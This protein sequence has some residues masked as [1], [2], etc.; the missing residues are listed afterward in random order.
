MKKLL[1]FVVGM[2]VAVAANAALYVVG[3]NVA[4]DHSSPLQSKYDAPNALEIE[5]KDGYYCFRANGEFQIGTYR[6][7]WDEG[8]KPNTLQASAWTDKA[9]ANGVKTA[10]LS[11]PGYEVKNYPPEGWA[12]EKGN[13][14]RVT[15]DLSVIE[16]SKTS[17]FSGN[18]GGGGDDDETEYTIYFY[19]NSTNPT[20]GYVYAHIWDDNSTSVKPWADASTKMTKMDPARWVKIGDTFC[21]VYKYTFKWDK[22]PKHIILHNGSNNDNIK[23][24]PDNGV[25][26]PFVN[27]GLYYRSGNTVYTASTDFKLLNEPNDRKNYTYHLHNLTTLEGTRVQLL[28]SDDDENI[29]E[30]S[31]QYNAPLAAAQTYTVHRFDTD[32]ESFDAFGSEV[33]FNFDCSESTVNLTPGAS[34]LVIPAGL[35]GRVNFKLEL[36]GQV[37]V[38]LTVSGGEIAENPYTYSLLHSFNNATGN[39]DGKIDFTPHA[40]HF[41]ADYVFTGDEKGMV[42]KVERFQ[43]GVSVTEKQFGPSA[44]S[45]LYDPSH[46]NTTYTLTSDDDFATV[47][48][49]GLHGKVRFTLRVAEDGHPVTVNVRGG[50]MDEEYY[51]D[52]L[53]TFFFYAK[54]SDVQG[55]D[56][57]AEVYRTEGSL[58]TA[59]LT[60]EQK[61]MRRTG[62]YIQVGDEYYPVYVRSFTGDYDAVPSKVK[63]YTSDPDSPVIDMLP[64]LNYGYYTPGANA[65]TLHE[66]QVKKPS[67]KPLTLYFHVKYDRS[68][69]GKDGVNTIPMCHVYNSDDPNKQKTVFGSEDEK[70]QRIERVTERYSIW[71]YELDESD[72]E[73]FNAV[74]FHFDG[75]EKAGGYLRYDSKTLYASGKTTKYGD[76]SCYDQ[77]NWTK[78]IYSTAGLTGNDGADKNCALQSYLTYDK[79]LELDQMDIENGGRRHLYFVGWGKD[80]GH[81]F[82]YFDNSGNENTMPGDVKNALKVDEDGGCFY[83]PILPDGGSFK[84]SWLSVADAIADLPA[85]YDYDHSQREWATFDLGLIGVDR[86]YAYP[87][88]AYKPAYDR[89]AGVNGKVKM[90]RNRSIRYMNYNQADWVLPDNTD[91]LPGVGRKRWIII[92]THAEEDGEYCKTATITSFDPN[93]SVAVQVSE[94]RKR[95]EVLEPE[96]AAAMHVDCLHAA[97]ANGHVVMDKVNYAVANA[98]VSATDIAH[99]QNADF[100][101]TYSIEVNGKPVGETAADVTDFQI[102]YFPLNLDHSVQNSMT[103]RAKYTDANT[104]LSFHS[105]VGGGNVD[106]DF[107]F[108]AP[109]SISLTGRFVNEGKDEETG[110]FVFGVYVEGLDC[111][112]E[113]GNYYAYADFEFDKGTSAEFMSKGCKIDKLGYKLPVWGEWQNGHDWS[114]KLKADRELAPIFIHD[115]ARVQ[116]KVEEL[117]EEMQITCQ[118][119][120]VYPFMYNPT[121]TFV[122]NANNAPARAADAAEDFEGFKVFNSYVKNE[123]EG[124]ATFSVYRDDNVISG[125]EELLEAEAEADGEV[126]YYTIS[127]VRVY[128]EPAPGL[129]IRRQGADVKKVLV[130]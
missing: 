115:V 64:F 27:N 50:T 39:L 119:Y 75:N 66:Q 32:A 128:G 118:I 60:P 1:L 98:T 121:A 80:G 59:D 46:P 120:A 15:E 14:F 49:E 19:E 78:Y 26:I 112:V 96:V 91:E 87:D 103:I 79:F 97:E 12:P 4:A 47:L 126:E 107:D 67:E 70:M 55:Q 35:K 21:E 65:A 8:W 102:D 81:P 11:K 93:P 25:G 62:K 106:Y 84:L 71:K 77:A 116:S 33:P 130:K 68:E 105:H 73:N 9:G 127:G 2:F 43:N 5:L 17:D 109:Q 57:Y 122:L 72:L 124:P 31:F 63:I 42:F 51:D 18:G 129:Y 13:Y 92:D 111:E 40:Y 86:D 41:D 6:T 100:S 52:N 45:L 38:K 7:G 48:P 44:S 24:T 99:V 123:G 74:T 61:K 3:N 83:L 10:T 37:P 94:V 104:G 85:G 113:E 28:Q 82:V 36:D 16:V 114:T 29:Y 101:R 20:Y 58:A 89:Y 125:L 22:T 54:E 69:Y 53:Y 56:V 108:P 34:G 95:D 117:P 90:V 76:V 23:Y 30:G 110:E 88:P